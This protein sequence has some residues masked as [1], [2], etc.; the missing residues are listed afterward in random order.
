MSSLTD[1]RT[2]AGKDGMFVGGM[3]ECDPVGRDCLVLDDFHALSTGTSMASPMVAGAVALLLQN[4]PGLTQPEIAIALRAGAKAPVQ[5]KIGTAQIGAGLLDIENALLCLRGEVSSVGVADRSNSWLGLGDSYAHPDPNWPIP[6]FLHLRDE[7]DRA[8]DVAPSRIT[9]HTKNGVILSALRAEAPGFYR[10]T[11]AANAA[12]A[13][14][15]L[16]IEARVDGKRVVSVT[17]DIALDAT[18]L[19][20]PALAGRGC[21]LG[22]R[23]EPFSF[24]SL[25]GILAAA[26]VSLLSRRRFTT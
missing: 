7:V 19:L 11:A 3:T 17:R 16:T 25:C 4:D 2:L 6:G 18:S 10:F 15:E 9:L 13:G 5:R 22:A 8:V 20:E 24:A 26:A 23:R 1:P 12:T 14:Q 21:S